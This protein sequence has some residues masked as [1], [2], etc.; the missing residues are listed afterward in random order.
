[1]TLWSGRFSG[2]LNEQAWALNT[3]LPFDRRL[4]AQD[5]R[6]SIAWAEAIFKAG[7]LSA[8]EQATIIG[9]LNTIA[10]EFSS[11]RFT[12]T[13]SDEDIHTAVERRLGELIGAAA[14][15]LHT[16]RSR[17]DQVATDFRLWLL[18]SLP[19]L[20]SAICILQSTLIT[21][22]EKHTATLMPGYTHLQRAQPVTLAHWLMSHFW[23]L[24]R[25]KDRL[26]DLRDRTAILPLGCGALAGT[27]FPVNREALTMALGF[28]APAPNSLDAVS[29]RDFAAEF[30]FCAA[31]TSI[32]LSK[33]SEQIGLFT[34][35]EFGFFELADAFS[36]GSSLMP[37]KKNPDLFELARGK[38]GTLI[39]LLTGLLATLKGLPST[40]DKDLQEDKVPVF[41][42]FDTLTA[43]LPVLA[44]ALETMTI[45]AD[46][47][48]AAIDA[49]MLATDLAE[50]LVRKGIPFRQAH[51]VAGKAVRLAA[52]KAISLENLSLDEWQACG[53]F[54]SDVYTVFDPLESIRRHNATGGT[55]P[56]SVQKQ[57][58]NAKCRMMNKKICIPHSSFRKR[59]K[60]HEYRYLPRM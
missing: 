54:E 44:G 22:A 26:T 33:L 36:T 2:K 25:D 7:I 59:R 18:D 20:N 19:E 49:N 29:D 47:M 10:A 4:A 40:Y 56:D 60:N 17:N 57:I 11:G 27:G 14:G 1:M 39:G 6:G 5:V 9:G 13:A 31:L 28:D 16:G 43:I 32:H 34:T 3:S 38:T 35:T 21:L 58:Q 41:Q 15:K 24:E 30:L 51:A 55:S 42:A 48:R 23:A 45:H 53:A 50:Y 52:D 46:R 37:Q 8:G 12:F